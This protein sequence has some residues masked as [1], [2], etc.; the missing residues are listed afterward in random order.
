[1]QAYQEQYI[2]NAREI[3]RLVDFYAVPAKDY[4]SWYEQQKEANVRLKAL[5]EENDRLLSE[6]FFPALDGL[7]SASEEELKDLTDFAAELMDWRTNLDT[8]IF[9][10]V[11]DALLSLARLRRDRD[12]V[13][14]ELYQLGMGLY[15]ENRM[16]Q[17]VRSEESLPFHIEDEMVFT[18]AGSYLKYFSEIE[19][20]ETKGYIIR[21]LA[22]ISIATM[23]RRKRVAIGKRIISILED[24]FY[25]SQAPGLPW[26]VYLRRA[27]QQMSSN[28]SALST[29]GLRPDE[30]EAIFES[31]AVVFKP[32]E[33]Q[34]NPNMRWLWPYYEMEYSCGFATLEQTL[35][36]MEQLILSSDPEQYDESGLYGNV[37]LPIYYGALLKDNPSFEGRERR[38]RFLKTGYERML[39]MLMTFPTEKIDA[40][41]YYELLLVITDYY[42]LPEI[43]SYEELVKEL[44]KRYTGRL[45]IRARR[46]GE[47]L[48]R[49]CAKIFDTEPDFFD[50]I[51][52]L[53]GMADP[54]KK[55]E[56]LLQYAEHCGFF[57]DFG[58]IKMN[59]ERLSETRSLFDRE[60]R[61]RELHTVSGWEDL[62]RRPSTVHYADIALGHHRYYNGSG[63]YPAAYVR[64]R[65]PYRQMV[66]VVAVSAFLINSSSPDKDAVIDEVI[67]GAH[68][69]FSP[70]VTAYLS[71]RSFREEVRTLLLSDGEDYYRE[72]YDTMK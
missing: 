26:D 38:L 67:D 60:A 58:M 59:V 22:N 40:Q 68:R 35:N 45:F 4:A 27:H 16:V 54:E 19:K 42:E 29:G 7:L 52:F 43:M 44:M 34:N 72:V 28:R 31:C 20:E 51:P 5:K 62:L 18:E 32:E 49:F 36:R 6:H 2:R 47:L 30:L 53:Q 33:G 63:G 25:R 66:D 46:T 12:A 41:L 13:I 11:H 10:L 17:G 71:D 21:G 1:M 9:V 39:R 24:P 65:C 64:N 70:L 15:Y 57:Y 61:I 3:A 69:R 14:R 56:R 48:K 37:Q 50:D 55:R 23:D 8:G